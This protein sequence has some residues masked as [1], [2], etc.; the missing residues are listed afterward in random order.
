MELTVNGDR[1]VNEGDE[2]NGFTDVALV[3]WPKSSNDRSFINVSLLL[4]ILVC[5]LVFAWA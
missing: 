4:V 3:T 5:E 1:L 2:T